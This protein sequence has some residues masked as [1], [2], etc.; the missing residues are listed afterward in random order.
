MALR[1]LAS[2]AFIQGVSSSS[3][4]LASLCRGETCN[5]PQ[6]PILDY[7][8]DAKKCVCRA[9]PCWQDDE[10]L[11]HSCPSKDTP[12]LIFSYS[13]EGKL[14]CGCSKEPHYET[15]VIAKHKCAGQH[16][17]NKDFPI[18]DYDESEKKCL[19]RAHPCWDADGLTH[20]CNDAKFPILRYR[21]DPGETKGSVKKVCECVAK[22]DA[23]AQEEL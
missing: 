20:A 21:E 8:P 23:P 11:T 18:L 3:L 14:S 17:D 6:H 15:L 19:C 1:A 7:D 10:G 12:H 16:C 13:E 2:F 22:L 5:N 9:H 4:Y